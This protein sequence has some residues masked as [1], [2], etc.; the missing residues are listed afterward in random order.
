VRKLSVPRT[1][2][3]GYIDHAATGFADGEYLGSVRLHGPQHATRSS[4]IRLGWLQCVPPRCHV[5]WSLPAYL[6]LGKSWYLR[7]WR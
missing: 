3:S 5:L 4:V 7:N 6:W 2:T 1:S